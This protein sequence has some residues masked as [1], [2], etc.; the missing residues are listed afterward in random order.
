M[1]FLA[2]VALVAAA[3]SLLVV[4]AADA[5]EAGA[6][7]LTAERGS[8]N[9]LNEV[10]LLGDTLGA[11]GQASLSALVAPS[12]EQWF[13]PEPMT[14]DMEITGPFVVTL[15]LAVEA[16][17]MG[18]VRVDLLTVAPNGTITTI[19]TQPEQ[20]MIPAAGR[21]TEVP[22]LPFDTIVPAGH[23]L[24]IRISVSGG[25][26]LTLLDYGSSDAPSGNAAPPITI[27]DSDGDGV[28]D[29]AERRAGTDPFDARSGGLEE[30]DPEVP[31]AAG[32]MLFSL[33]AAGAG[34][35]GR[36]R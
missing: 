29:S 17:A 31:I 32:F 28:G 33:A 8:V 24:G 26:V 20:V 12:S 35:L 15:Y 5:Q 10:L 36:F 7:Y 19:G 27:L 13:T 34:I 9:G 16:D 14:D 22:V 23:A 30:D 25:T 18:E 6:L 2:R 1:P 21:T 11:G 3:L 4:P